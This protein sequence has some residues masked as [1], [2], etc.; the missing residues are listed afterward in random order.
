MPTP[1]QVSILAAVEARL[2]SIKTANGYTT[3]AGRIKRAT[4]TPFR[5]DDLPALNYW[6]GTDR[7]LSQGAG[8]VERELLVAIEYYD[9]TRDRPFSDVAYELAADV[10]IAMLRAPAAPLT[11][12]QPE[13]TLG[14]LVRSTQL[15]TATPQIGEGQSPW[16]GIALEYAFAYRVSASNPTVLVS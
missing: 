3:T 7:R 2:K 10:G 16:C 4:L 6:P 13:F 15:L 14:G 8:W 9:R 12:D 1:V 5:E 11:S